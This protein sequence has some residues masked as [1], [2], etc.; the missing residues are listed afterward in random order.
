MDLAL[1]RL[2]PMRSKVAAVI[3]YLVLFG[4]VPDFLGGELVR[5]ILSLTIGLTLI[6]GVHRATAR[7]W[8]ICA[9]VRTR[10]VLGIVAYVAL[11]GWLLA[12]TPPAS[13]AGLDVPPATADRVRAGREDNTTDA[14]HSRAADSSD[15]LHR[16]RVSQW[17]QATRA[18]RLATA[19][20]FVMVLG[21]YKRIPPDLGTR[22]A[23]LATCISEA[24]RT[25][26]MDH[27][28][29][30]QIGA[31]CGVLLGYRHRSP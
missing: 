4:S 13:E 16:A 29:V 10:V 23:E 14:T 17:R 28:D 11:M 21:E 26:E 30:A 5:G 19:A 12:T 8:G 31:T 18:E 15:T 27:L 25:G 6:P 7:W 20:D 9:T 1:E 24:T 22:S 2:T 3:G